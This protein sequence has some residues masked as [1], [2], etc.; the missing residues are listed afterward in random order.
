M[1]ISNGCQP[2]TAARGDARMHRPSQV[3]Y[4]SAGHNASSLTPD[5]L[6]PQ[7]KHNEQMDKE[8]FY[9]HRKVFPAHSYIPQGMATPNSDS[10]VSRQASFS[11]PVT[12]KQSIA[13]RVRRVESV[14]RRLQSNKKAATGGGGGKISS[15]NPQPHQSHGEYSPSDGNEVISEK[16]RSVKSI[17]GMFDQPAIHQALENAR[18]KQE[19]GSLMEEVESVRTETGSVS[20]DQMASRSDRSA[21]QVVHIAKFIQIEDSSA[22]PPV[23]YTDAQTSP[24]QL[25]PTEQTQSRNSPSLSSSSGARI[26]K[27][28]TFSGGPRPKLAIMTSSSTSSYVSNDVFTPSTERM[29]SPVFDV[30][31]ESAYPARADGGSRGFY[32]GDRAAESV[33]PSGYQPYSQHLHLSK[34]V[35]CHCNYFLEE[36]NSRLCG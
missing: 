4:K 13:P 30:P 28:E 31:V 36:H 6:P 21:T 18:L 34:Q 17:V 23:N 10:R 20:E 25:S 1:P 26:A 16:G 5:P 35:R 3:N 24:M 32:H 12:N 27:A 15:G 2:V 33:T 11:A 14:K 8:N 22:K 19:N 9:K 29:D 7:H